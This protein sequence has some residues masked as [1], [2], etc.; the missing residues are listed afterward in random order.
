[1]RKQSSGSRR[2]SVFGVPE[3]SE[4]GNNRFWQVVT[5]PFRRQRD[6]WRTA[7]GEPVK[8]ERRT[9]GEERHRLAE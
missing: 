4:P 3:S 8:R 7:D 1:M 9:E 2:R 6:Y 5:A